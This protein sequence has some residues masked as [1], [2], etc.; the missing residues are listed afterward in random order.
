MNP[1]LIQESVHS[2]WV[3]ALPE[4]GEKSIDESVFL[5]FP[6]SLQWGT[7]MA[8]NREDWPNRRKKASPIV[9]SGYARTEYFIDPV[10]GIAAVFGVQILPWGNKEVA[11]T[12][13]SKLEELP[14]A[15][16]AD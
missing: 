4:A 9:R 13:F 12:L 6:H 2:I 7:A 11:Q 16:L 10:N 14:Y 5:P 15:A 8:I 3:P 1:I